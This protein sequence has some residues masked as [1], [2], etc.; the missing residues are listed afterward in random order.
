METN[1]RTKSE[2]LLWNVCE[3]I[4][5]ILQQLLS[6]K[7][8]TYRRHVNVQVWVVLTT[9]EIYMDVY[10]NTINTTHTYGWTT[11]QW[12]VCETTRD[13]DGDDLYIYS[14]ITDFMHRVCLIVWPLC[15]S[16]F[17]EQFP[18]EIED[19]FDSQSQTYRRYRQHADDLFYVYINI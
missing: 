2:R 13:D 12:T 10:K 16:V 4:T 8:Y 19:D 5:L 7:L 1:E 14:I 9:Q 6:K 3:I 17:L 11:H 15:V 18:R